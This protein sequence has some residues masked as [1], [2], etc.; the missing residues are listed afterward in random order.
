MLDGGRAPAR[1]A[2]QAIYRRRRLVAV[3]LVAAV[4]V[5]AFLLAS[6][7]VTRIAGGAPSSAAGAPRTSAHLGRRLERGRGGRSGHGGRPARRHAVVDRGAV[8]PDVDVRITVDR[9]IAAN[10]SSP[11]VV[12]QARAATL[13]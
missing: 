10:G 9:L 7:A 5:V 13:S 8:A 12:G 4:L 3:V 11:I 1:V 2:Q 6:A